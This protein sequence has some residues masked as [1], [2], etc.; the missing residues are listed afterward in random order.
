MK[1]AYVNPQID[2]VFMDKDVITTSNNSLVEVD[3]VDDGLD[4]E[5]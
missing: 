3:W 5:R 1:K 2:Y 4:I